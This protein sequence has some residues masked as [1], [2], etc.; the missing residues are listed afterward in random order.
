M[1]GLL[2]P[3]QVSV[4]TMSSN[5]VKRISNR[6]LQTLMRDEPYQY[7]GQPCGWAFGCRLSSAQ[8]WDPLG[9]KCRGLFPLCLKRVSLHP[10]GAGSAVAPRN[11]FW[12]WPI[13]RHNTEHLAAR[14]VRP[15]RSPGIHPD[16]CGSLGM[17]LDGCPNQMETFQHDE[18]E[19]NAVGHVAVCK[20]FMGG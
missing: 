1:S 4:L 19:H 10:M 3:G 2:Q 7:E 11:R 9:S 14:V 6:N 5:I 16:L 12:D 18:I 20:P 13:C 8:K 17:C 15:K